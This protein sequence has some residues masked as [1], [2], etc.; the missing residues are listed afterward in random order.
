MHCTKYGR[1]QVGKYTPGTQYRQKM[2]FQKLWK[3]YAVF[4]D[5]DHQQYYLR[6]RRDKWDYANLEKIKDFAE[7]VEYLISFT[8][9]LSAA[10]EY[11]TEKKI[12]GSETP[13]LSRSNRKVK[14]IYFGVY[15]NH[16]NT[17]S[18]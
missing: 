9:L 10:N 12:Q 1:K 13:A 8:Y 4:Y 18:N 3:N 7:S 2:R 11:A 6:F 16:R 17:R 14:E 5:S 15:K